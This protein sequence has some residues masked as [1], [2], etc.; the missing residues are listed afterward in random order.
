LFREAQVCL[1]Q[2]V[3]YPVEVEAIAIVAWDA[4]VVGDRELVFA[5]VAL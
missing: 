3:D 1:D 2:A 4:G 5:L